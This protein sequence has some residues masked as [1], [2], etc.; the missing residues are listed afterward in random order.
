MGFLFCRA[1]PRGINQLG[2]PECAMYQRMIIFINEMEYIHLRVD[3]HEM[4]PGINANKYLFG[5]TLNWFTG[6]GEFLIVAI[7]GN[8]IRHSR[9]ISF[10]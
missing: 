10:N 1:L 4:Y 2:D 6:A 3:R 8:T 9:L 5:L 7:K